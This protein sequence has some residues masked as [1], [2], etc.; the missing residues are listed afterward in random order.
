MKNVSKNTSTAVIDERLH[1]TVEESKEEAT[2]VSTV[3]V[4]IRHENDATIT[5]IFEVERL[6]GLGPI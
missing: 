6:A 1:I 3:H 4:S 2:D 5:S